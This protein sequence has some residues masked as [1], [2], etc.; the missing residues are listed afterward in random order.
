MSGRHVI[1]KR[2]E[3]VNELNEIIQDI[4]SNISGGREKLIL[5]YEPSIDDIYFGDELLKARS[6]DLKLCQ[7]TVG[8]HRDDM[9]FSEAVGHKNHGSQN[10]SAGKAQQDFL[11]GQT[12]RVVGQVIQQLL[13][14]SLFSSDSELSAAAI[15]T[16]GNIQHSFHGHRVFDKAQ[17]EAVIFDLQ[18]HRCRTAHRRQRH[19]R[20]VE[21]EA[22]LAGAQAAV[23]GNAGVVGGTKEGDTVVLHQ[24]AGA[25][26]PQRHAPSQRLPE[27]PEVIQT[28]LIAREKLLR[29][30]AAQAKTPLSLESP[31]LLLQLQLGGSVAEAINAQAQLFSVVQS[32]QLLVI[33][34]RVRGVKVHRTHQIS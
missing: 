33:V 18:R 3:F 26:G 30:T 8:P 22:A 31:L 4:H 25:V 11:Q 14:H 15:F 13:V 27:F 2:R 12:A 34:Q 10:H 24:A 5:K 28:G 9:L 21:P 29:L 20:V 17:Q 7:T 16:G 1:K 32:V 19:R 23:E 6:R